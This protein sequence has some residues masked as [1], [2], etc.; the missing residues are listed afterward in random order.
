MT[1]PKHDEVGRDAERCL[2]AAGAEPEAGDDLVEDQQRARRVA[3]RRAGLRGTR[4]TGATRPMLAATGSTIT[5]GD[6]VVELGH[7]VVRRP[8]PCRATADLGT[9]A[10]PESPSVG[11]AAAAGGEQRVA[12]AVVVARELHDAFACR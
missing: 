6:V 2:R 9:P 7:H 1:L 8:R 12:V 4:A 3:R 5:H 10:E 11:D